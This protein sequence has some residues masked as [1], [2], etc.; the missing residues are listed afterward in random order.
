[1]TPE[2]RAEQIRD[3]WTT[4]MGRGH[5]P[6]DGMIRDIAAAIREAVE[7]E[8]EACAKIAAAHDYHNYG[9]CE[10]IAAAIRARAQAGRQESR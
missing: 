2:E 4:D 1:M 6:P 5:I 3:D 7:A 8:R 10:R 9:V